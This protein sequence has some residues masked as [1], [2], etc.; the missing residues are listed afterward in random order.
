M[1][2]VITFA[3]VASAAL[4]L[5]ALAGIRLPLSRS[6]LAMML[7]FASGALISAVAFELFDEAFRHGGVG[8]AGASFLVEPRFSC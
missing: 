1:L 6:V 8:W 7:G 3:L 2:R 4:P 5:G